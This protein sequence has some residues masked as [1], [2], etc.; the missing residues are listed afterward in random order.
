MTRK[1]APF[2]LK[3]WTLPLLAAV[4]CVPIAAG[5][6]LG[7]PPVGLAVG[8]L[9]VAAIL[10]VAG[11]LRPHEPIEV[12]SAADECRRLLLVVLEPV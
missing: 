11:R 2:E 6:L 3:P 9:L 7:G 1:Q 8:A 5:F 12:A 4:L 10:V